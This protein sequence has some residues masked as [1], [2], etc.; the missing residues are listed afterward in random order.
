MGKWRQFRLVVRLV[1]LPGMW[2]DMAAWKRWL[3]KSFVLPAV[4]LWD[5]IRLVFV[6]SGTTW[7][8]ALFVIACGAA[9]IAGYVIIISSIVQHMK[10]NAPRATV[11]A[12]PGPRSAPSPTSKLERP[13]RQS[14]APTRTP[15]GKQIG[16]LLSFVEEYE[17]AWSLNTGG[18]NIVYEP[19]WV[20]MLP[21]LSEDTIKEA[22]RR[23]PRVGKILYALTYNP[24]SPPRHAHLKGLLIRDLK[25]L[26]DL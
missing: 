1:G 12:V 26:R 17:F 8:Q 4:M 22:T 14:R 2:D 7:D 3:V 18:M 20:Q 25:A 21:F 5:R 13:R 24:E 9:V 19:E 6:S 16:D 23:I 11:P 10:R 15:T